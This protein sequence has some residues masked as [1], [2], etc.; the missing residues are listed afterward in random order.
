MHPDRL[1]EVPAD[2][3]RQPSNGRRARCAPTRLLTTVAALVSLAGCASSSDGPGLVDRTLQAFGVSRPATPS[4][5]Q[6]PTD[7]PTRMSVRSRQVTL[8][9][10]A[11]DILNTDD[12]G[13]SLSVVARIYKLRDKTAFERAQLDAFSDLK[14]S[15]SSELAQDIVEAKE[16]VLTPGQRH[17]V[18]ETV[19]AE[20]PYVGVVAL[21]RAP[22]DRRWRFVFDTKAAASTG[23]TM[24]VHGCAM[25]VSAG[26]ALD[27][28]PEMLRVAGV[29]CAGP[30][31]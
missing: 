9:L 11:G 31:G 25:S 16:I 21:F 7:L 5:D 19:T 20:A 23:I 13:R 10:H 6:V 30:A 4:I 26:N 24:G 12:S 2:A 28:A 17:E 15:R 14:A 29:H 8:R 27:V 3:R 22:A 1:P 18:V